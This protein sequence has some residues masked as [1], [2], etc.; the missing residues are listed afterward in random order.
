MNK[1]PENIRLKDLAV[2][3][4][5]N[6]P[7]FDDFISFLKTEKY[8]SLYEFVIEQNSLKAKVVL[9]KYLARQLPENI[10]LYDGAGRPYNSNKAKWL[11]LG[12]IFRDAPQQRLE[13][14]LKTVPAQSSHE[15]KAEVIN[16][17]RQYVA[18]ILPER[19]RWEWW[20]I[21][22][23]IMER[24]E[25][26]RRAIKGT[27]FEA[28]VRRNLQEIF[29][30][31][32][33]KIAIEETQIKIGNETYD[34]KVSGRK[35]T[36]LIPVK[37]R[38]TMGGGHANLFT[39]DIY[40]AI[41]AAQNNGMMCIP[42]IIAESWKGDIQTLG[43]QNFIYIDKNPNQINVVEPLLVQE[44]TRLLPVFQQIQ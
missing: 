14:F 2:I 10:N 38:E 4:N 35:G 11:M 44:I 42:I 26:S 39:R 18:D 40:K 25:G 29:S 12:W 36:I 5:S 28:I 1:I 17:I 32:N 31:N 41:T 9:Q 6:K 16:Q 3:T 24:L 23:V 22:E 33:I 20:P 19:E 37:T 7:F 21:A 34:I 8:P 27:L 15:R 30:I 13:G 43:C